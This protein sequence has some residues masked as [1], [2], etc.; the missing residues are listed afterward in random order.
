[1]VL[2]NIST[3]CVII[4]SPLLKIQGSSFVSMQNSQFPSF[5][6]YLIPNLP[7]SDS[8]VVFSPVNWPF[9]PLIT[10][11]LAIQPSALMFVVL[12]DNDLPLFPAQCNL[13]PKILSVLFTYKKL[14]WY[15]LVNFCV[16]TLRQSHGSFLFQQIIII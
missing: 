10:L 15:Y 11:K 8:L 2:F 4:L 3:C 13:I 16:S 7:I 14:Y 1:M 5:V 9:W 12:F 6:S